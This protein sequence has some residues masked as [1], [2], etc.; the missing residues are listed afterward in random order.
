MSAHQRASSCRCIRTHTT[1]GTYLE[2]V[3]HVGDDEAIDDPH[4]V[5]IIEL[6]EPAAGHHKGMRDL[7]GREALGATRAALL[8]DADE[9]APLTVHRQ[10]PCP[11]RGV[12]DRSQEARVR[13]PIGR[14]NGL[15]LVTYKNEWCDRYDRGGLPL[16]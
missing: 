13:V 16:G 6:V 8:K 11:Q 12:G 4:R 3:V 10:R 9:V 2:C 5:P 1:V 15:N 14:D 7:N